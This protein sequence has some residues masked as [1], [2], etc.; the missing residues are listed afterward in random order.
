MGPRGSGLRVTPYFESVSSGNDVTDRGKAVESPPE[1]PVPAEA[2]PAPPESRRD[3]LRHRANQIRIYG[4]T[5]LLVAA[6][7]VIVGLIV[8]N[9]RQVEIGWVFGSGHASLVWI[10]LVAA[11]VGWFGGLATSIVVRRW[12]RRADER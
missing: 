6:L 9:T 11:V 8:D 10:T 5:S 2:P 1:L 4:W 12:I 7:V 3:R